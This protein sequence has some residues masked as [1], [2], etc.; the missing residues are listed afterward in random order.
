MTMQRW[1]VVHT[2]AG[3][4][5]LAQG[6]LERQ[7]FET[8]MPRHLKTRRHARRTSQAPAPLFPRYLFV[9]F[10]AGNAPWRSINGTHGVSHL[11]CMGN[12]PSAVPRGVVSEIRARE[13]EDGFV[14]IHVPLDFETGEVVRVTGGPLAQQSGIFQG[15]DD[16]RRVVIL[17]SM[18]GREMKVSLDRD[19]VAAF[20]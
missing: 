6:H 11:V 7:G 17:L 15:S 13:N 20:A 5:R 9:R 12:R 18:L 8:Y 4:E 1:Y 10:D 3:A 2:R 16:N 19:A 14:D